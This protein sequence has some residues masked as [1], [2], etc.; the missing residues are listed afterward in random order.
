MDAW[1]FTAPDTW[2]RSADPTPTWEEGEEDVTMMA[3]AGYAYDSRAHYGDSVSFVGAWSL[4][5]ATA[6]QAPYPYALLLDSPGDDL[7]VLVWLPAFPDLLAYMAKYERVGQ[8]EFEQQ[9]W[10]DYRTAINRLFYAWHGH[11]AT[12]FCHECDPVAYENRQRR[13]KERSARKA[14]DTKA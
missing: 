5:C 4:W 2:T 1:I 3:R 9:E 12:S 14:R 13:S 8:S 6:P 7:P 11:D 10:D